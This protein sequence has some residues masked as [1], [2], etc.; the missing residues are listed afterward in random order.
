P[1]T[2][3]ITYLQ[4]DQGY[5]NPLVGYSGSLP[6]IRGETNFD[7]VN[8]W[9]KTLGNHTIKWGVDA[10]RDRD[11][12]LQTQTFNPRGVF[13]FSDVVTSC[14]SRGTGA[15]PAG[16][17]NGLVESFA[18]FLLDMPYQN[19]PGHRCRFPHLPAN[20]VVSLRAGHL[21]GQPQ[22]HLKLRLALG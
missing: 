9:T 16:S 17:P 14:N 18:A 20:P 13:R 15:C 2:S 7:V 6:W 12:L 10:R 19:R 11:E 21:A 8:N 5:S 22:A 1:W 4:I 3:G